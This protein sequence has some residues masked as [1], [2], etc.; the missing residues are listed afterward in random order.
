MGKVILKRQ[1]FDLAQFAK[2]VTPTWNRSNQTRTATVELLLAQDCF[3][4]GHRSVEV[5]LDKILDGKDPDGGPRLIDPLTSVRA[6]DVPE[7]ERK[8]EAWLGR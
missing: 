1:P 2:N 5:L 6:A 4:W 8:W 3:G 7:W